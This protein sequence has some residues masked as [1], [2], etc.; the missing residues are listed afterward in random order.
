V[1]VGAPHLDFEMWESSTG[2]T[3]RQLETICQM[4]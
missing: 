4:G 1:G 3:A 2:M